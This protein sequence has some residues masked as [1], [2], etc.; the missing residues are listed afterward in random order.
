MLEA[1]RSDLAGNNS[2]ATIRGLQRDER[3]A[4][5]PVPWSQNKMA[6]GEDRTSETAFFPLF[7]PRIV[8]GD[9]HCEG[10]RLLAAGAFVTHLTESVDLLAWHDGGRTRCLQPLMLRHCP[11]ASKGLI[12]T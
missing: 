10:M 3:E 1:I 6:L 9:P 12:K 4:T 7:K 8:A 11:P 2:L 5:P